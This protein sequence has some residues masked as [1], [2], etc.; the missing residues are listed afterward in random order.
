LANNAKNV[1]ILIQSLNMAEIKLRIIGTTPLLQNRMPQKVRN[2]LLVGS[3]KKTAAEKKTIKHHPYS[4][5]R[6][7]ME[8]LDT[9]PTMGGMRTVAVKAAMCTAALETPGV[10]KTEVQRLLFV[11]GEYYPLYGKP[12]LHMGVVRQAD[13]NRT[14]DIRTRACF[15]KWG[16]DLTLNYITPQFGAQSVVSM[17]CNA[18]LIIGLLDNRQEKGKGNNGAFRV[19]SADEQDDEWDELVQQD[20][21]V[22]EAAFNNPGCFD[23]DTADLVAYYEEEV[24]RR[25]A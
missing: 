14:P 15:P 24:K 11:P 10:R 16:V 13:I 18:G 19:I 5:Y 23:R 8:V 21:A 4:E 25:A 12:C 1:E 6:S 9:G 2:G 17:L 7:A 3:A 22:Q 20:R